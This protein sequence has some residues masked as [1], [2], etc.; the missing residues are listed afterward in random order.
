MNGGFASA[1]S[2]T[3]EVRVPTVPG[4]PTNLSGYGYNGWVSLSWSDPSSNGGATITDYEY[5]YSRTYGTYSEW[6][7]WG[8]ANTLNSVFSLTNGVQYQ[9]QVRAVNSVG[10]GAESNTAYAT[11]V[12]TPSAPQN[13]SAAPDDGEVTLT[14]TAPTSNGGS[15]ITD[16]KYSYRESSS[17]SWGSWTSAGTDLSETITGLTNGTEYQFYVRAV[18]SVGDGSYAGL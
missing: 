12:T 11:P 16:Y 10:E 1:T 2:D 5:R 6:K 17:E 15:V 8:N 9:F 7:S 14:W 13:L 3:F 18:N 4:A